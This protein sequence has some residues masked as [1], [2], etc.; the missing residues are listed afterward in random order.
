[1]FATG[2]RQCSNKHLM[3]NFVTKTDRN[4]DYTNARQGK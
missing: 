3:M 4:R 2:R 1:M